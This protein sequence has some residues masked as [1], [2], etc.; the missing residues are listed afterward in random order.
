MIGAIEK[1]ADMARCNAFFPYAGDA[2]LVAGAPATDD[3]LKCVL[4]PVDSKDYAV[5]PSAEQLAQLRKAFPDG[6]C[7]YSKSGIGQTTKVVTW[8]VFKGNGEYASLDA[9]R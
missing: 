1:V 9:P 6:V 4:K 7:D 8:A 3:V 2:R 5:A